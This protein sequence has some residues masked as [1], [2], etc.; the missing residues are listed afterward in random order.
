MRDTLARRSVSERYCPAKTP[1]L[2]KCVST[3]GSPGP[4]RSQPRRKEPETRVLAVEGCRKIQT[5][6]LGELRQ[7]GAGLMGNTS[8]DGLLPRR[9]LDLVRST[10]LVFLRRM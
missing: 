2:A 9:L 7:T 5:R 10:A 4:Q 8:A 1:D 3:L 6:P